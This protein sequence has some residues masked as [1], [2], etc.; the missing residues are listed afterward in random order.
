MSSDARVGTSFAGYNIQ[1]PV[2]AGG[3]G[4]VYEAKA[5]DGTRVALKIA[6]PELARDETFR[7]R[8]EREAQIAKTVRH[9]HVVSALDSGEC[10]GLPY[11]AAQFIDGMSLE[12]KLKREGRLGVHEIVKICMEVGEGLQAMYDAGL[13]HRDVKPGN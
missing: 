5:P 6:K 8:F 11:L 10:D 3:M 13:V 1:A 2:A 9:P 4:M 7:R 12:R